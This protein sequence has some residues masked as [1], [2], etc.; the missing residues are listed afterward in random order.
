MHQNLRRGMLGTLFAGGLLALGSTAASAADTTTTGSDGILSGT[1]VT[2]PISI[3][4]NLGATSLGLL[5]DSTATTG[6][7]TGTAP[8]A[9]TGSTSTT[10]TTSTTGADGILSGTQITAPVTA[11]INLGATSVGALGDSTAT[12]GGTTTGTAPAA[13]TGSTATTGGPT[14]TAPAAQAGSTSTTG[15]D[16]IL[17]GTQITAP[18]TVPINLGAT[19]V[20]AWGDSTATTGGGTTTGTAP[21]SPQAPSAAGPTT[22]G[23]DGILSGTQVTAP[24]SAPINLGATSVGTLGDSTATAGGSSST[25]QAAAG[26][27]SGPATTGAGGILSGTQ[28]TAPISA[29]ISLGATSVGVGGGSAATTGNPPTATPPVVTPPVVTPPVVTAPVVN[30]PA[31]ETPAAVQP[32]NQGATGT[33]QGTV[34]AASA[35]SGIPAGAST[36]A[37]TGTNADALWLAGL[38]LGAGLLMLLGV[39]LKRSA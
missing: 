13:P 6:G 30:L 22:T 39:R 20:G 32:G 31:A 18:V 23:T 10:G 7:T 9:P 38:F 36:L 35:P 25:G 2:A 26:P 17:S 15:A 29:P 11:P 21:A 16:G 24:I 19:S 37:Y 34:S 14:G 1:Q 4:V 8:A 12:S 28:I 27:L 5:G 33:S 3:P